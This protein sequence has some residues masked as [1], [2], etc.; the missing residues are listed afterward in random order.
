[1]EDNHFSICSEKL[2]IIQVLLFQFAGLYWP[3]ILIEQTFKSAH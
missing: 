1:M 2:A 3:G